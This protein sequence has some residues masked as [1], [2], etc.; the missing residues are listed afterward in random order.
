[1]GRKERREGRPG[2]RRG[3]LQRDERPCRWKASTLLPCSS[4]RSWFTRKASYA[5]YV[6]QA[7]EQFRDAGDSSALCEISP[8]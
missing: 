8:R 5:E 2:E 3:Q 1:M 7:N 6:V 4:G